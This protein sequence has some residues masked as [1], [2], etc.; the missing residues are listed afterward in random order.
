MLI[1]FTAGGLGV[2]DRLGP[3]VGF[4]D[5]DTLSIGA[6]GDFDVL[7]SSERPESYLGD[8]FQLNPSTKTATFRKAYYHWGNG[9]ET[10]LAIERLDCTFPSKRLD[11]NEISRRLTLLVEY[12]S[13]YTQFILGYGAKQRSLGFVNRLEHDDWAGK[14][15][16]SGQHYYQGIYDLLP[17]EVLIVETD[18][19]DKVR[20]WN[21]QVNDPIWNTIDWFTHQSS[22][23][24]SQAMIDD[25][26]KFRAVIS[27][28]DPGVPN[29][30]DTG[31]HFQGSL[32]LRWMAASSGPEPIVTIVSFSEVRNHLPDTTPVVTAQQR[33]EILR[34]RNISAQLRRRW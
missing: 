6:D 1:D 32:M 33:S 3:S 29:W 17:G 30:L 15:G 12:V 4:I 26:G 16:G 23:N 31:G 28:V 10:R 34:Q 2:L 13:R 19:P 22:L 5:L 11:A 24:G 8:W 14:G 9:N 25:D 21:I 7:L 27:P 20:Y 18:V